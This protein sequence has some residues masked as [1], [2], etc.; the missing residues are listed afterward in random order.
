M[1]EHTADILIKGGVLFDGERKAADAGFVAVQAD[2]ILAAGDA[3]DA[4][5]YEGPG[6]KVIELA[7]DQ[8]ILP[9][10]HDNHVHLIQ[11]G[12]LEKFADL[13]RCGT[14]EEAA[15]LIAEYAKENPGAPWVVGFGWSKYAFPHLPSRESLDAVIPDRPVLMM[16]DE[17]HS[18]W[19]NTKA[20]ELAGITDDT[21]DPPY[22]QIQRR[23]NGEA[24]GFLAETALI[25]VARLTFDFGNEQV[26]EL[27]NL[28]TDK[29]LSLG[30]TSVTDM[31]PYLGINLAY[32]DA[33]FEMAAA[34]ELRIRVNAARDL[35]EDLDEV[36]R[37]RQRAE[38]EGGGMY[39]IPFLKQF[40]DGI[41]G[42]Y[43]GMLIEDYSDKPGEKGGPLLDIEQM[44]EAILQAHDRGL[45]VRLHACGDGAV[46]AALDG[47]EAAIRREKKPECRHQVEHIEVIREEDIPRFGQLGVIASVQPEHIVS[48]MPSF[49]DNNYPELLGPERERFTWPFRSLWDTG[50]RLAGGSDCPVVFGD[51]YVG[52]YSG[53]ARVH[54]DGTPEGGWNPQEKLTIEELLQMY[55]KEAA[56]SEG[57]EDELGLIRPGYLA[58]IT[59]VDRDLLTVPQE[60]IRDAKA[61]LTMVGGR[62]LW[63]N[64]KK[65]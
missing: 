11:A 16:D 10:I 13:T 49:S 28:Y 62:I 31:A 41:P 30:I 32:E 3:K 19:V 52:M 17:L 9:G 55:T 57:R 36:V 58:D 35:F 53:V 22:G 20:L 63:Y 5:A 43:T 64:K 38:E 45:S 56:Y 65:I 34:G 21:P 4:G 23:E 39:R 42:N 54:D 37:L 48:G 6:T 8:L 18:A 46:K 7:E 24:T 33:Y 12:M 44:N 15:D 1:S 40:V 50:A 14:E 59:V 25:L 29:A 47:Y 51:P 2:R 26:K 61:V 60:A 27:V